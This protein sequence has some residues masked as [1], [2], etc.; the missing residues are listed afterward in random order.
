MATKVLVK[1]VKKSKMWR[2]KFWNMW[3][4]DLESAGSERLE[5]IGKGLR[6]FLYLY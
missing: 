5:Q 2:Q 1:A 4:E 6:D 3:R